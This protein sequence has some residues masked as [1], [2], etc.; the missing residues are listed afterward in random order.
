VGFLNRRS[1]RQA[2]EI[3]ILVPYEDSDS[4]R[5]N[6]VGVH[7]GKQ[8][9]AFVTGADPW[10]PETGSTSFPRLDDPRFCDTTIKPFRHEQDGYMFGLLLDEPEDGEDVT[11]AT[12]WPNNIMFHA[13]WD[14]EYST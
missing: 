8:F 4:S 12:L 14:G 9:M 5:F 11:S 7:R 1:R 3:K 10:D 13:P 2:G 6:C